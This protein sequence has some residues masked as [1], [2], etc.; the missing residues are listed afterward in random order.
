MIRFVKDI[1]TKVKIIF[2]STGNANISLIV[3]L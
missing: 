3:L 2:F 1:N